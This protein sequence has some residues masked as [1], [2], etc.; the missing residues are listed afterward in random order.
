M[1]LLTVKS[2]YQVVIPAAVRKAAR[3]KLGDVLEARAERGGV[4]LAPKSIIDR[5]I[6]E[7]LDDVKN[8]RTHGPFS[9]AEEAIAFLH[10][11]TRKTRRKLAR[12]K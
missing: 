6:M 9:T 7:G 12:R 8:G 4:F 2:K 5:E 3:I 10:A 11:S 1:N